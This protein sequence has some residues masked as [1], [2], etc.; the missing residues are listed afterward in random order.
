[1]SSRAPASDTQA[2]VEA[3]LNLLLS[4]MSEEEVR[5]QSV[6]K[7]AR[8][9]F[10]VNLLKRMASKFKIATSQKKSKEALVLAIN[11]SQ[12]RQLP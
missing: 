5:A 10:P 7:G 9:A 12:K 11:E 2:E 6:A 1:M 3:A 8:A 4:D